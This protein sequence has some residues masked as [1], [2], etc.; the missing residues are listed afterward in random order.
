MSAL[1]G[2]LLQLR[3]LTDAVVN[4]FSSQSNGLS[5]VPVTAKPDPPPSL[6][7]PPSIREHLESL[8][9]PDETINKLSNAYLC[10]SDEIREVYESN[11]IKLS[12]TLAVVQSHKFNN[13]FSHS[14]LEKRTKLHRDGFLRDVQACADLTIQQG[15]ELRRLELQRTATEHR[16]PARFQVNFRPLLE[17]YFE[18]DAFPDRENKEILARKTGMKYRQIHIWFQNRRARAKREG[19]RLKHKPHRSYIKTGNEVCLSEHTDEENDLGFIDVSHS[20]NHLSHDSEEDINA[21]DTEHPFLSRSLTFQY[22][23]QFSPV[24]LCLSKSQR[25]TSSGFRHKCTPKRPR[26]QSVDYNSIKAVVEYPFLAMVPDQEQQKS[27]TKCCPSEPSLSQ[28]FHAPIVLR[29]PVLIPSICASRSFS[30]AFEFHKLSTLGTSDEESSPSTKRRRIM[31][32]TSDATSLMSLAEV[33]SLTIPQR[34]EDIALLAKRMPATLSVS[35]VSRSA[36]SISSPLSSAES[37]GPSSPPSSPL[38][39]TPSFSSDSSDRLFSG[40]SASSV[41]DV[42]SPPSSIVA[43]PDSYSPCSVDPPSPT[44]SITSSEELFQIDTQSY[45]RSRIS[46][47]RTI[48]FDPVPSSQQVPQAVRKLASYSNHFTS[49]AAGNM[50]QLDF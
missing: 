27:D 1:A 22:P 2:K 24:T 25:R 36:T 42:N 10:K 17:H 31:S 39:R 8:E 3:G 41:L 47:D 46:F 40:S 4:K 9:L 11:W 19:E 44:P 16:E 33:C 26:H 15:R 35:C 6:P 5:H 43:L 37:L 30:E 48:C 7:P 20:I 34:H 23:H 13:P 32:S 50:L 21:L 49:S 14:I 45:T 29:Q 28:T 12:K 38:S 18:K